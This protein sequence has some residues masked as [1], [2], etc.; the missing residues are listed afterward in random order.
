MKEQTHPFDIFL[1]SLFLCCERFRHWGFHRDGDG[2]GSR[3]DMFTGQGSRGHMFTVSDI[4][5]R[6]TSRGGGS[7]QR[8]M[9]A[10]NKYNWVVG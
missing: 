8:A 9:H 1:V 3:G 2:Q 6:V 4:R 10:L 7:F 5:D